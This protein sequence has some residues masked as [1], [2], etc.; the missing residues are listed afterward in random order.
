[1]I[2]GS[3]Y[4]S[5]QEGFDVTLPP[6]FGY[7]VTDNL[8]AGSGLSLVYSKRNNYRNIATGLQ[9]FVRYY[10]GQDAPTRVFAQANG[11]IL[12]GGDKST[13]GESEQKNSY[14]HHSLGA[15]LGLAHF[16]TEQVG[17]EVKLHYNYNFPGS[18]LTS[19]AFGF[20]F[21]FQIHLPNSASM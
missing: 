7:F 13:Y 2:G 5:F 1:M 9:P 3:G 18:N 17:L 12:Y 8:A 21:G 15:R 11:N 4:G 20:S 16:I 19:S 6:N 10:F 14:R